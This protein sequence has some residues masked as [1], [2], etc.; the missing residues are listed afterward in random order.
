MFDRKVYFDLVRANLFN[1]NLT[2]Q[3]VD[4]QNDILK[5]WHALKA[6]DLRWLAYMLAT[7][8]H[9]TA[10]TMWPI[11]EY[12]KG[13]GQPYGVID[14]ET[15]QA[16]YGRG[17]VQLTWRDNYQRATDELKLGGATDLVWHPSKALDPV[18]AAKI[19]YKGMYEGWFR[20]PNTL[21]L[22][23]NETV[24]NP[25]SA[26]EIINGDTETTGLV[27]VEYHDK[28]LDALTEAS[29]PKIA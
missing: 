11:E 29:E 23:F 1:G 25:W 5:V 9:E 21:P 16:Y 13:Q 19:M 22:Y 18:I 2:Q 7:T 17:Y 26:R 20:P 3:Q 24:D 12:G 14:P 6:T 8:Y 28:F 4:G 10:M 15:N 27:I